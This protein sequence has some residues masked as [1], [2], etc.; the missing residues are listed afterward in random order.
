[1]RHSSPD[2]Q[3]QQ[4]TTTSETLQDVVYAHVDPYTLEIIQQIFPAPNKGLEF[5]ARI[6]RFS[7]IMQNVLPGM[8]D[9]GEHV[10]VINAPTIRLLAK[11]IGWGYDT[12]HKYITT[13]CALG[14][15]RKNKYN[16]ERQLI[17]PLKRYTLP[18]NLQP[19]DNL[20]GKSRPK[21]QQF[22]RQIKARLLQLNPIAQPTNANKFGKSPI[23][24]DD[25]IGLSIFKLMA[26]AGIDPVISKHLSKRIITEVLSQFD[27][28]GATIQ[29]DEK[30]C[31]RV[32]T[33]NG[34]TTQLAIAQTT[35]HESTDNSSWSTHYR[36]KYIQQQAKY[37]YYQPESTPNTT[38]GRLLNTVVSPQS[39][40]NAT[41]VSTQGRPASHQ[42]SPSI[43]IGETQV[44]WSR[45]ATAKVS[46][47]EEQRRPE[48]QKPSVYQET[49]TSTHKIG[50]QQ[51]LNCYEDAMHDNPVDWE[52][53]GL[54]TEFIERLYDELCNVYTTLSTKK[55][56]SSAGFFFKTLEK[57]F[58]SRLAAEYQLDFTN[59]YNLIM[60]RTDREE[61]MLTEK[62][63]NT[64][65]ATPTEDKQPPTYNHPPHS[66]DHSN[67][68]Q[69]HYSQTQPERYS[70]TNEYQHPVDP[71]EEQ[72]PYPV[73]P[74]EEQYQHPVDSQANESTEQQPKVDRRSKKYRQQSGSKARKSTPVGNAQYTDEDSC[75]PRPSQ[76]AHENVSI[77]HII[78]K[79]ILDEGK[80]YLRIPQKLDT[81]KYSSDFLN[82]YVTS[83]I[84]LLFNIIYN[85]T[86][87]RNDAKMFLAEIFDTN[88]SSTAKNWYN[89]L[90]SKCSDSE[91]L[92][93]GFI[94]TILDLHSRGNKTIKNPGGLF[95]KKCAECEIGITDSAREH[96]NT[97]GEL[98]YEEFVLEVARF[99]QREH[100]NNH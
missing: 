96:I 6:L 68:D 37:A 56:N 57:N 11:Q 81:Q 12:T 10:A 66:A 77:T 1:M 100:S 64:Q 9:A 26:S 15:L 59:V 72:Y 91:S 32:A 99:A 50:A 70:Y 90:F 21:V 16:S 47:Q 88:R 39:R 22:A 55:L 61:L 18:T 94:E 69:S 76:H 14:L 83:N 41:K 65:A 40:L 89:K 60:F 2:N 53:D 58:I 95:N 43:A 44:D 36:A 42:V 71:H 82:V 25:T 20:I 3:V 13:F 45:H 93:A 52:A 86:T 87:L 80:T 33:G 27:V 30:T 28:S 54:P 84:N 79:S 85:N 7:Q 19:L 62:Q 4:E 23:R 34:P 98:C 5:A 35:Q 17:F 46:Y 8:E 24:P 49:Y 75:E 73:D 29:E 74:H 67:D 31:V 48:Q 63:P 92:L 38:Q 97:Y 78:E 51:I